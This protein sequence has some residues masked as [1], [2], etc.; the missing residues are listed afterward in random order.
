[1]MPSPLLQLPNTFRAFYGAFTGLHPV[2]QQAIEPVLANRDLILQSATGSGKTEAVLA[3]CLEGIIASDRIRAALYI[4]PTRAL[5]FDI[6]RRFA[7]V[8]KERLG[9]RL[10][11]IRTGDIKTAGGGRPDIMLT[12]PES[13]DVMLGSGNSDLQGFLL[14]VRTII[15]DEVHPFV[16][17]YRGQQLAYLMQRLERRIAMRLQKIALSATIADP[18]EVGRFLDFRSDFVLLTEN[19]RREIH[20][21]FIHLKDDENELMNLLSDLSRKWKYRKILIFANSRGRCDKIFG[22]LNAQGAFKGSALLHYSNINT[23][24]RQIVEQR[25]RRQNRAVCVATSTLELGIDVGDVDAVLLFEPPDSVSAFLQRTG[26]ANRR[27]KT[28]HFWGICRGEGA[29][30]QLLRFLA[31]IRI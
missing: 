28:V 22:L 5:A 25:F 2:Q 11:A 29:G 15:I 14:R 3:P 21:R 17:Q 10:A 30:E 19:V 31:L 26:R 8:L 23:R 13:L 18:D 1:M 16:H 24:E 12:T 7:D 6:Q 20:P 9:I 4:V 27:Q